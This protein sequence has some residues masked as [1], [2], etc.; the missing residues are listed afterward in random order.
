MAAT[1]LRLVP[2]SEPWMN[3]RQL[4]AYLGF[5]TRWVELRVKE[6]MPAQRWGN[7]LR[8]RASEV[9]EWLGRRAA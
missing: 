1:V 5:S 6:G 9:E 2:R 3:K 8:F 7:R 4:A